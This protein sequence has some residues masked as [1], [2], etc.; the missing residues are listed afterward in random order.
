MDSL[1]ALV[2]SLLYIGIYISYTIKLSFLS[3]QLS[4]SSRRVGLLPTRVSIRKLFVIGLCES[5]TTKLDHPE[6][7]ERTTNTEA[8]DGL[9]MEGS[10]VERTLEGVVLVMKLACSDD[11]ADRDDGDS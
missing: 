1:N 11:V 5:P 6:S 7:S 4:T 3:P 8:E 2:Q 10:W 9:E